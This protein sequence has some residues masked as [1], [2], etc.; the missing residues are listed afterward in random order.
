M[1][2]TECAQ[3]EAQ[4][5]QIG[6]L[7][8]LVVADDD[9]RKIEEM[10]P[11]FLDS[12]I[13]VPQRGKSDFSKLEPAEH[14]SESL[15]AA[16]RKIL[17]NIYEKP[18]RGLGIYLGKNGQFLQGILAGRARKKQAEFLGYLAREK[19]KGDD[20][21]TFL[22]HKFEN[23]ELTDKTFDKGDFDLQEYTNLSFGVYH[24]EVLDVK[25]LFSKELAQEASQ[26]N[27][28]PTQKIKQKADGTV[29]VN[30]KASG[31]KSI[32]WHVFKWGSGCKILAP[33]SLKDEY[34]KY[35]KECLENN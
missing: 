14:L 7:D 9:L 18:E 24:G 21:Y 23:L 8:A 16:V 27:F 31:D 12:V 5:E 33:K 29:E 32:I 6:L 15:A 34:T 25:L 13:Y 22:L 28:H 10:Y 4:F 11:E 20:I 30:F 17:S 35:L 19:A 3:L 1:E 2:D 26:Y